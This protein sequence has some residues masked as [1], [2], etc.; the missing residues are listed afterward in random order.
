MGLLIKI[1]VV[2]EVGVNV[3]FLCNHQV[4]ILFDKSVVYV[5]TYITVF[6]VNKEELTFL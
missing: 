5:Q 2:C 4:N 6:P 1:D 3:L